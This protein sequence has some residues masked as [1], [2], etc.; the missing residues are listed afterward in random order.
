MVDFT[1]GRTT[2]F[3]AILL[4]T[5]LLAAFSPAAVAQQNGSNQSA[6]NSTTNLGTMVV[7][8]QQ[9][10]DQNN[11]NGPKM[12][13]NRQSLKINLGPSL[14]SPGVLP[15]STQPAP[16]HAPAGQQHVARTPPRPIHVVSP[17]YPANAYANGIKG[18]VTVGFTIDKS[19]TTSR[20]HILRSNPP[21]VFDEAA[22]AA[23]RQ[24][25]FQPATENNQPVADTVSQTLVFR[26]P[27]SNEPGSAQAGQSIIRHSGRPPADSV[28]GNI[29]PVHL[30]PPKY[31]TGAYGSGEGGMVTVSFK[32]EPDGRTSHIRVVYAK[33][34]HIFNVATK[35]AVRQWRFKHVSHPTTV[36][37]TIRFTP[38][39]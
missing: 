22:E 39:N 35:N 11:A 14:P 15:K 1:P 2:H 19:G 12:R 29:H 7:A 6:P 25:L 16:G 31:P 3:A 33:P 24:W 10:P 5:P 36:V 30:V 17:D 9:S 18:S 13:V 37:Q 26:P 4:V 34:R 27:Q 38:P 28:P 8:P 23:V 32:V 20:I 21:G